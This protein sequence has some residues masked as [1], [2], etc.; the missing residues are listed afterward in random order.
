MK[1][2][3]LSSLY[4]TIMGYISEL[5]EEKEGNKLEGEEIILE[6]NLLPQIS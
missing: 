5:K 1:K 2:L 3:L 4:D 6:Q